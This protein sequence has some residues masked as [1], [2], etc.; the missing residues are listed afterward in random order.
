MAEKAAQQAQFSYGATSNLVLSSNR[1][2]SNAGGR[3]DPRATG[4]VESLWGKLGGERMGG[5]VHDKNR[6]ENNDKD[7]QN[8]R[9]SD[10]H[11]N[12]G[13]GKRGRGK[14]VR[15]ATHATHAAHT[16]HTTHWENGY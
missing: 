9:K 6:N 5:K 3:G 12:S 11:A 1:S 4:E 7:K 10:G 14:C 2:R 8:K 15:H 16:T 13:K